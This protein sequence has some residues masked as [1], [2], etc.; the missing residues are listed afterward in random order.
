MKQVILLLILGIIAPKLQ[1]Q[2]SNEDILGTSA[3]GVSEETF[4]NWL[5]IQSNP[6]DI[7]R[8]DYESLSELGILSTIQLKAFFDYRKSFG[9]F[10]SI[11]E[12]QSIPEL[13]LEVLKKL[14]P[15]I[16][17][18]QEINSIGRDLRL[19]KSWLLLRISQTLEEKKG[20]SPPTKTSIVRYADSPVKSLLRYKY[21]NPKNLSIGF[22]I[23]K[24]EGENNWTDFTSF[25][26]QIQNKGILRNLIVGDYQLQMGQGLATGG[27]FSLG[28]SAETI[29]FTRKPTLGGR[30][31]TS[32]LESG[33]F[34][35]VLTNFQWRKWQGLGFISRVSR[36]ANQ[37][38]PDSLG[39]VN[40]SSLQT[41]GFHRT[42]SE[43]A[44]K[45]AL[46]ET[47]LGGGFSYQS[48]FSRV[49][50]MLHY[51][52]FDKSLL[53]ANKTYNQYEFAGFQNI[54][55]SFYY[56]YTLSFA[57]VFGEITRS[58][59]GGYGAILGAIGS[60]NRRWDMSLLFRKF[61]PDF[62]S[63]YGNAFS[64]N[65]RN[66]NETGIYWGIKFMPSRRWQWTAYVDYFYFPWYKYLVDKPR[67]QGFETLLKLSYQPSK[68]SRISGQL[69]LEHK[70]ENFSWKES[71]IENNKTKTRTITEV[72]P[73]YRWTFNSYYSNKLTSNISIQSRISGS[74]FKFQ[75][76]NATYGWAV[77][78]DAK[79]NKGAWSF[80]MRI[81]YF[82]T[83][84]YDNRQY[85]YEQDVQYAFS[86]P[87]YYGRGWR[88]YSVLSYDIN[89]NL[90]FW[91][92]WSRTDY[93]NQ[94]TVGSG[95]DEIPVPHR[96]DVKAQIRWVF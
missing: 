92:R 12:L 67:T 44:D 60:L 71:Y 64:E 11:Y 89:K 35:G 26:V 15:L 39:V 59:S 82:S 84:D 58:S 7:N 41:S 33:F 56:N 30:P 68:L 50:M 40:V 57:Q 6:I 16:T 49:G 61:T 38:E 48:E 79:W 10:V 53:K 4:E 19:A 1:A 45:N 73:R 17:C 43:I 65:T 42:T 3:E 51:T 83:Q 88:Y 32:T 87:A 94:E 69:R 47:N 78:Q 91:L 95:L 14:A 74:A 77:S 66:I 13:S 2:V 72:T 63:F 46:L 29:L 55:L 21:A 22:T 81:A 18:S 20:F 86:F 27:G 37:L 5:Q 76:Q 70:E 9:P 54:L 93:I 75:K 25:H 23:E 96:S 80:A 28:K 36:D 31:Y 52:Y 8:V 90:T 34:R 62:H 24:D 85:T